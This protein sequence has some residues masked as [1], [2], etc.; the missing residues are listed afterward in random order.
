M[1]KSSLAYSEHEVTTFIIYVSYESDGRRTS[2]FAKLSIES[3]L[4]TLTVTL[5]L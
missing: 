4:S 3:R 5:E 2:G 1:V